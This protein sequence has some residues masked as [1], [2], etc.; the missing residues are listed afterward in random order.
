M[1]DICWLSV[2][3]ASAEPLLVL[4][5]VTLPREK[6]PVLDPVPNSDQSSFLVPSVGPSSKGVSKHLS[7]STI[8]RCRPGAA[9]TQTPCN[10]LS[11]RVPQWPFL[12]VDLLNEVYPSVPC[13]PRTC[14]SSVRQM[15]NPCALVGNRAL[16]MGL[17]QLHHAAIAIDGSPSSACAY[18]FRPCFK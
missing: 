12:F 17:C 4:R 18:C 10:F 8:P 9:P 6:L 14:S 15:Q 16:P 7:C 11:L 5:V 13:I 2:L 3:A 1:V